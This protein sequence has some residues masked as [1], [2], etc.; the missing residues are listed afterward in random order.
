MKEKYKNVLKNKWGWAGA[1]ILIVLNIYL[2][3]Y[4]KWLPKCGN[5]ICGYSP[6]AYLVYGIIIGIVGFI[7]GL[8]LQW[9]YK[10]FK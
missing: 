9:L 5:G 2:N 3:I 8:I 6:M 4:F 7:L 1:I 10:R